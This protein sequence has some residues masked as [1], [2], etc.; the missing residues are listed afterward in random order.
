M[1]IRELM[2][3]LATIQSPLLRASGFDIV[4]IVPL[5]MG[6]LVFS[7]EPGNVIKC[8]LNEKIH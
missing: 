6:N 3:E 2:T 4:V 5:L 8:N 7:V 1:M